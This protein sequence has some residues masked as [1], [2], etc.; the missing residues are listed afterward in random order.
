MVLV[1]RNWSVLNTRNRSR[2][3]DIST[4]IVVDA[5]ITIQAGGPQI[6]VTIPGRDSVERIG[7]V[8]NLDSFL[9][10]VDNAA[11]EHLGFRSVAVQPAI[12]GGE[13]SDNFLTG[14]IGTSAFG[15]VHLAYPPTKET[16]ARFFAGKEFSETEIGRAIAK[17][18]AEIKPLTK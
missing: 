11:P 9:A 3:V 5:E 13:K 15:T 7:Y 8:K 16:S 17:A 14:V 2:N 6:Q 1:R 4:V 12:V 18:R 10:K